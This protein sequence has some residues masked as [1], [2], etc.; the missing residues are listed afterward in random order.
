LEVSG[1]RHI[2]ETLPAVPN[3]YEAGWAADPVWE[4][5][6]KSS[7]HCLETNRDTL[8][9]QT[10]ACLVSIHKTLSRL[11]AKLEKKQLQKHVNAVNSAKLYIIK[12]RIERSC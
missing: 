7:F 1:Q 12:Q 4:F 6:K 8:A 3:E 9:A 5:W 2:P 11:K 10:A